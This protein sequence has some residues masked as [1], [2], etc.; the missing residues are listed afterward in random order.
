MG[1]EGVGS[2]EG[3]TVWVGEPEEANASDSA[4]ACEAH[5]L[6]REE[7]LPANGRIGRA[8]SSVSFVCRPNIPRASGGGG[9]RKVRKAAMAGYAAQS[10]GGDGGG[11][12]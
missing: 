2:A 7:D 12:G 6:G 5:D 10:M 9:V 4:V 3:R 1:K 8:S 11:T